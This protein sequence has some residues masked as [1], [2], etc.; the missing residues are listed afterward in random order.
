[1]S[2]CIN[3]DFERCS[4]YDI[5]GDGLVQCAD[6]GCIS[7][8]IGDDISSLSTCCPGCGNF[9]VESGEQCDEGSSG[10]KECSSSCLIKRDGG[11]RLTA[12]RGTH[13]SSVSYE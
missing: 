9:I 10:N 13:I 8:F 5:N 12:D 6:T 7:N 1:M 11:G 2:E 4:S 3:D